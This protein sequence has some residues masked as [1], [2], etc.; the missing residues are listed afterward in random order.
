MEL[1]AHFSRLIIHLMCFFAVLLF[2]IFL[3]LILQS[4]N[5]GHWEYFAYCHSLNEKHNII[6]HYQHSQCLR[7]CDFLTTIFGFCCLFSCFQSFALL[8]S[9]NFR[10]GSKSLLKYLNNCH[11]I[12]LV[13]DNTSKD[14]REIFCRSFVC[15]ALYGES[16]VLIYFISRRVL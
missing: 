6:F 15:K 8:C 2:L 13:G 3:V 1:S 14:N 9:S 5:L 4:C 12:F 10:L 7:A 16:L 11:S